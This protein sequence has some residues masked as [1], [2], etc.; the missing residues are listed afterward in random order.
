MPYIAGLGKNTNLITEVEAN[1]ARAALISG[2]ATTRAVTATHVESVI[3]D[4]RPRKRI[5]RSPIIESIGVGIHI[6][7]HALTCED[8][9]GNRACEVVRNPRSCIGRNV[10]RQQQRKPSKQLIQ[11]LMNC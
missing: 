9:K 7:R 11:L 2:T 4:L 10:M 6:A 8:V 5:K 1:V 3:P